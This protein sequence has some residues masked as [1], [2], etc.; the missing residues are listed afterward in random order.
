MRV[1]GAVGQAIDYFLFDDAIGEGRDAKST[2]NRSP[3]ANA[4]LI[5]FRNFMGRFSH[6]PQG[7]RVKAR[8]LT[9][10]DWTDEK[11]ACILHA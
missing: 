6:A 2:L 5:R 3:M 8:L 11:P 10:S 1:F 9:D 4:M 7:A